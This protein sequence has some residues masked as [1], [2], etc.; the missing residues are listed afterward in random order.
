MEREGKHYQVWYS[1][2][3]D[4]GKTWSEPALLSRPDKASDLLTTDGFREPF[5]HY[6]SLADDGEGTVH[7]VWGVGGSAEGEKRRR[8][9]IWYGAVRWPLTK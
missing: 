1:G 2:S 5:G 3:A 6:M 4:G 8:G 7:A 9:E